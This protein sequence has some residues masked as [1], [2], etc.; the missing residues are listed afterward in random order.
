VYDLEYDTAGEGKRYVYSDRPQ[1]QFAMGVSS[2]QQLS[3]KGVVL[4][5]CEKGLRSHSSHGAQMMHRSTR[6]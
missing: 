3:I 4:T 5:T 2:R 6:V 1:Q